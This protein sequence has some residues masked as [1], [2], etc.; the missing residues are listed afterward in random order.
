MD[1]NGSWAWYDQVVSIGTYHQAIL[2]MPDLKATFDY[3]P[4]TVIQFSGNLLLH[5]VGKWDSGDRICYAH[6]VKKAIFDKME[7][8]YPDWPILVKLQNRVL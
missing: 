3:K 6:F 2:G 1:N 8:P 7:I 4:G 5:E